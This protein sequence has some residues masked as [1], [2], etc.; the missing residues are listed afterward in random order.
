MYK[1]IRNRKGSTPEEQIGI[2][3]LL[4]TASG[5]PGETRGLTLHGPPQEI[6]SGGVTVPLGRM[7]VDY[8]TSTIALIGTLY[9][10]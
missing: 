2:P 9:T 3:I 5:F 8:G 6:R 7:M 10:P 1:D 4:Q